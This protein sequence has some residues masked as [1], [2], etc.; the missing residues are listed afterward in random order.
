MNSFFKSFQPFFHKGYEKRN[1]VSN[2]ALPYGWYIRNNILFTLYSAY[3]PSLP[4]INR[5]SIQGY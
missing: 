2:F 1:F 3:S 4:L 5:L